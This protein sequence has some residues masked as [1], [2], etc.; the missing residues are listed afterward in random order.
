MGTLIDKIEIIE[1][2]RRKEN[3]LNGLDEA[4]EIIFSEIKQDHK[5]LFK[6]DFE[7]FRSKGRYLVHN[8]FAGG[9][10]FLREPETI[11]GIKID[12]RTDTNNALA[13]VKY[14]SGIRNRRNVKYKPKAGKIES[15]KWNML[16]VFPNFNEYDKEIK[17]ALITL[18]G[19][20]VKTICEDLNQNSWFMKYKN[21]FDLEMILDNEMLIKLPIKAI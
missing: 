13:E 2:A 16:G 4:Y 19:K 17:I 6:D 14:G 8:T 21:N 5:S 7:L 1:L 9:I 3:L 12:F 11:E 20:F 15:I 10:I 18:I